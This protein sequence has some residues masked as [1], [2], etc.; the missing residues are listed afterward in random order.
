MIGPERGEV[1]LDCLFGVE[2]VGWNVGVEIV[3]VEAEGLDVGKVREG[4]RDL[5]SEVVIVKVE[6]GEGGKCSELSRERTFEAIHEEVK[7]LEGGESADLRGQVA[8]NLTAA[9]VQLGKAIERPYLRRY[10]ARQGFTYIIVVPLQKRHPPSL[11]LLDLTLD[12]IP[13]PYAG[14]MRTTSYGSSGPP[15]YPGSLH[16][17]S[18]V[19]SPPASPQRP[20]AQVS[21]SPMRLGGGVK[22][23]EEILEIL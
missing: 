15:L 22:C 3:V 11:H 18:G 2:V 12:F 23:E 16:R 10:G 21:G 6:M 8:A 17:R 13:R 19:Q 5:P 1:F 14:R 4:G 9:K 7:M 20:K